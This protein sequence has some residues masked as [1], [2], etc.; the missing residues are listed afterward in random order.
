MLDNSAGIVPEAIKCAP[1]TGGIPFA[2]RDF[3]MTLM[4]AFGAGP[5][6]RS[7]TGRGVGAGAW[8][9]GEAAVNCVA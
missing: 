2:Q 7:S 4:R 3:A 9:F 6:C 8:V 5:C 1:I